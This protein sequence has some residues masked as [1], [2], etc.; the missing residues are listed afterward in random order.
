MNFLE[1]SIAQ[2]ELHRSSLRGPPGPPGLVGPEGSQGPTG[3]RGPV[4]A[5][6]PAGPSGPVGPAGPQGE[7]GP[8]GATGPVGPRGPAGPSGPAGEKGSKGDVGPS[9]I[10]IAPFEEKLSAVEAKIRSLAD[11]ATALEKKLSERA[12][13]KTD[14]NVFDERS[15]GF[16][17]KVAVGDKLCFANGQVISLIDAIDQHGVSF[18]IPGAGRQ[19]CLNGSNCTIIT[20]PKHQFSLN[21]FYQ[22]PDGNIVAVGL[23]VTSK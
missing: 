8:I 17:M 16:L 5:I 14:C 11:D 2:L 15:A 18:N 21:R 3:E 20:L 22:S 1:T 23:W 7:L 19:I 13:W 10:N 12:N 9:L 4:G 6:G